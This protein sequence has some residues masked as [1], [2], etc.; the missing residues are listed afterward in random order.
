MTGAGR[1]WRSRLAAGLLGS[2]VGIASAA[3]AAAAPDATAAAD[4]AAARAATGRAD[5]AGAL[6]LFE[7]LLAARPDDTDL[8]IEAAR[9]NGFA[10]R[11]A[12]AARLYRRVLALAPQRRADVLHALAWQTLWS[13]DAA[14]ATALF[15]ELRLRGGDW[16]DALDGLG[17]AR[18]AQGDQGGALA[19]YRAALAALAADAAAARRRGLQRRV[20]LSLLWNDR[21]DEAIAALQALVDT[22]AGDRASRWALANALNFAGRHREALTQ[23]ARAGAPRGDGERADLARAWRWAGYEDR[24]AP[25][26]HGQ[27]EREAVWVR[28]WRVAR[29]TAPWGWAGVEH[30]LDRDRLESLAWV[31]GGGWQPAPGTSAE[32]QVRR[33]RLDDANGRVSGEQVRAQWRGRLG[34]PDAGGGTWWPTL[35]LR[36]SRLG[37][38]TA[39]EPTLRATWVPRDGWRV[40]GEA[41]REVIETPL[42]VHNQVTVDVWSLGADH[43]PAARWSLTG[44]LAGLRFDDGNRRTRVSGRADYA[45]ALKP[46][47]V[48]GVDA[49]AFR[50]S[51]PS[52]PER[53]G[54]GY[55]NPRRYGEWRAFTAITHDAR[56][57]DLSARLAV[58]A[59]SETDGWDQ[60]SRGR[61]NQ[62]ELALGYDLA[63]HW[64]LRLNAGGSGNG[65]GL[66]SGGAGYWR[67]TLGLSV[68]GWL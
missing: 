54:R 64:R 9:V 58:G 38:W 62:W 10:D 35:A 6:A 3:G 44:A 20:A 40:D 4:L 8:L 47:W 63:P 67:R 11:N 27:T 33:L 41:T 29:E 1:G 59:A 42:A 25:L 68:S 43:R 57:F 60:R 32:L 34:E 2:A 48:V 24:A 39:L 55:W 7:R 65:F 31:F 51:Q 21:P 30:A 13:G 18:Q 66:G 15:E 16:A 53:P 37:G 26:L 61:P 50:S 49:M 56:P 28:D 46:R 5:Y 19:A 22:D 45:L 12:E 52:G 14:A 17:Q 23:F 36:A